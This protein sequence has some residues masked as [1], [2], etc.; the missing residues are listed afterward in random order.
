MGC[1]SCSSGGCGTSS[2]S[3][4]GK[5]A[6]CQSAGSCGCNR[7]NTYDWLS[8]IDLP[9]VDNFDVVEVSFKNGA[10]KAFYINHPFVHAMTGDNVVVE[11]GGGFDVGTITLSGE[12]VRLQMKKKR[13]KLDAVLENVIRKA[14][15][16]DFQ[17]LQEARALEQ[18]TMV[19]AR[20]I[21]RTLKLDMKIGDVEYQGDKRKATFYYTADGRVDF[22]ELIKSYAK[23]FRVKIEMRQIG[24]RQESAM[25]GGLGSCGRELCCSTWL[26]DFKSVSTAAARYQNLAINQAK[27]SGQCGRLKC[28]LNFEL[29]TYMDALT[30][31]PKKADFLLTE[32]GKATLVKTDIFKRIMYY[33][34]RDGKNNKFYALELP[35]VKEILAINANGKRPPELM[36]VGY[37]AIMETLDEPDYE[38]VN[39]VLEL[40]PL[41]RKKRRRN[42]SNRSKPRTTTSRS[43]AKPGDKP[44]EKPRERTRPKPRKTNKVV[45][46]VIKKDTSAP[47]F[48]E[49]KTEQKTDKT[50]S[51]SRNKNRNRNRNKTRNEN[52]SENKPPVKSTDNPPKPAAKKEVPKPKPPRENKGENS[53]P[54]GADEVK[55]RTNRNRRR[56]NRNRP[57]PPTKE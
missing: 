30:D 7:K 8:D 43:E 26:T 40:A 52:R 42:K 4:N 57:K 56:N 11:S 54:S 55:K 9:N 22:R 46:K 14:N 34:Y 25:I 32:A 51:R 18:G 3:V 12:L 50:P 36:P 10:R 39:D 6:G 45:G 13:V 44:A 33:Q 37:Q 35:R 16:R 2:N 1:A 48:E 19:K 21:S 20:V 41:E 15:N 5:V 23:E 27:L 24:A 17:R 49:Q 28:C 47:N 31:F 53:K 38:A 29:D